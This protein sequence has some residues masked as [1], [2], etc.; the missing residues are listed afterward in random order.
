MSI[1]SY[2]LPINLN[3]EEENSLQLPALSLEQYKDIIE[4]TLDGVWLLDVEGH[5]LFVNQSVAL[6]LGYSQQEMAGK[7]LLQFIDSSSRGQALSCFQRS[8]SSHKEECEFRFS[9]KD[10]TSL[11]AL[12]ISAPLFERGVLSGTINL[13]IDFTERKMLERAAQSSEALYRRIFQTASVGILEQDISALLEWIGTLEQQSLKEPD[14]L[15]INNP[16]LISIAATK[17]IITRANPAAVDLFNA[18][19][20]S[21]LLGPVSR[22]IPVS[23]YRTFKNALVEFIQGSRK[24]E[25]EISLYGFTRRFIQALVKVQVPEDKAD[26]LLVSIIDITNR[27]ELEGALRQSEERFRDFAETAADWFWEMDKELRFIYLSGRVEEVL[28]LSPA[29]LLGKTRAE[30]HVGQIY[31]G[32]QWQEHIRRM[33]RHEPILSVE[34]AWTRPDGGKRFIRL[35]GK[36]KTGPD[37]EFLGYRGVGSDLTGV[38]MLELERQKDAAFRN[39]VIEKAAEG[40]CVCHSTEVFPYLQFTLWNNRMTEITGYTRDQINQK[41]WYQTLYPDPDIQ[42]RAAERMCM[43]REGDDLRG[44]EWSIT[45]ADGSQSVISISTSVIPSVDSTPSVL[46]LIQDVTARRKEQDAILEVAKG[47]SAESGV[48]FFKM[49]LQNLTPALGGFFAFVGMLDVAEPGRINTLAVYNANTSEDNFSY[50]IEHTPCATVTSGQYCIYT[51]RVGEIFP[52]DRGLVERHAE[53]YAGAPLVD[54]KGNPLGLLVVLFKRPIENPQY[55]ESILRIFVTR[56]SSELE[57]NK[58][59]QR[60]IEERKRFQDFAEI[61]SDWFWEMDSEL[62]FSYFSDRVEETIGIPATTLL[63]KTRREMI[64]EG[65]E[66]SNWERHLK[67][68]Q[69]H[70]PFR[71]FD[72]SFVR[73][74]G[75]KVYVRVSGTPLFDDSGEFKGYRGIGYNLTK[76]VEGRQAERRLQDR[77]HDAME[78]VPGGVI[79]FDSEDRMILCNSAYRNSVK[80]ISALLRPGLLFKELNHAL[81]T[82][83]LIDL[84]GLSIEEWVEKSERMHKEKRPFVLK[85]KNDRWIEVLEFTT[86]EKGTLIIRMDITERMKTQKALKASESRYRTLIEQAADG[87]I[88]TDANGVITDC[89]RS[90]QLMLGY[91]V[92]ALLNHHLEEFIYS[93]EHDEYQAQRDQVHRKGSLIIQRRMVCHDGRALP[94]EVSARSL[95]DGGIQALI[96]DISERLLSEERLRLSATVFESTREGVLIT[97][98]EGNVTAVNSAFTEI[99]GYTEA[100]VSGKNPS[101]LKSGKHP[102]AF[103]DEMWAA[104]NKAGYWRG[105]LWNRRKNGEVYP[106][107]QT[108]STVR[109]QQGKLTNYVA[110]FSDISDIKES[111]SQLE[112]LA[113][114]DPLTE[115]PNRLLFTARLDHALERARRDGTCLAVLFID[116]DLFKNINDSLGHPVGD[117]LL[118]KVSL[119]LKQQ[120]RDEDTVARLGGDEFT[121]LLEQLPNQEKAGNIASKLVLSLNTPFVIEQH[122]LHIT[123]SIGISIFPNDGDTAAMLLRNSDAAMYQAKALGR[124]G[125][126]YYTEEMTS[127]AVKR[128]LLENSLRQA[129]ALNQF[130]VYYQ[131]KFSLSDGKLIGSEALIRWLHPDMGLVPPDNFIPLAEDTGLIVPIG[132]WVLNTACRQI[133]AWQEQGLATGTVAVN[134]SGQQL[135]RGHLV[136]TVKDALESSGLDASLLELE[137]TESFIMDQADKAIQVLG[138]LRALGVTLSIDDFGTGY[139]SL[140]Y[141]KKLPINNLKIDKSFVRDIP[142][143]PNDEAIARAIISLAANMQLDVIAEGIETEDQLNF[144]RREGCGFGQGYL[145]SPP[146]TAD[147]FEIYIKERS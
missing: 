1:Y 26:P 79:L 77:L 50:L 86:Q 68:L 73:P 10:G 131:P 81:A 102:D 67:Q 28:G 119:R 126:Q 98:A 96:R 69:E 70:Q 38:K 105:E 113:H 124:N 127:S 32:E 65:N 97:D 74:D 43:M 37:G 7:P 71:D 16:E 139:S 111:E 58:T 87:L 112:Y 57:R 56:A 133:K 49:L 104:I 41:G 62:R 138:E 33:R 59:E 146:V 51:E 134:L 8:K 108:I 80:E 48:G 36:S 11:W 83:G 54:S 132:A 117:E 6:M 109:D 101:L 45:R 128:V 35:N 142:H 20:E 107:W 90:T 3:V 85:V 114:H 55:V 64:A 123:A 116:L 120:L 75:D 18:K 94:V 22:L 103:Y 27:V 42:A 76:E 145:F 63:G 110:V 95:P 53:G 129:I 125:Y 115:L 29:E 89:N 34:V 31:E 23:S 21:Q 122:D 15:F 13:L 118:Q 25:I 84:E 46:A 147:D 19:H 144:L 12:F 91:T 136:S 30:A 130:V 82:V 61:A 141:L 52:L 66:Q 2:N 44:E 140:S 135:Q 92:D 106:E 4:T 9:R 93:E 14:Q 60:I 40:L 47:V 78:S 24:I 137:I 99:T 88:V 121:V 17:I 143:D 72:Y 100:E 5:T 39:A